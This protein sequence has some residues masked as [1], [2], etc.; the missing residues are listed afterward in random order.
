VR[1][2]P[3]SR[4]KD[5]GI[6]WLGNLPAHWTTSRLK[7]LAERKDLKVEPEGENPLP[8][9][10]LEHVES[11]TGKLLPLDADLVPEGISNRFSR[12]HT[13]F[14][15]LR[16]Y[17]AKGCNPDIDG[18]C[19]SELLVLQVRYQDRRYFLYQLLTEGFISFVDSSTYGAKMPRASWE[20]IGGCILPSPPAAEQH[21]IADFL[22]RKT[23]EVDALVAKKQALIEKLKEKRSALI[24][25]TVT[26]GLPP[27]VARAIGLDLQPNLKASGIDW[28]GDVPE[29]WGILM[30]K[31]TWSIC[32]YG[33]SEPLSG[34]GPVRVLTMRN[35]VAGHAIIPDEGCL[36]EIA[37]QMVLEDGDLLFN[38]TNS[39]VHVGKVGIYRHRTDELVTFASYLVRIRTNHRALPTFMNYLLNTQQL[40]EFVRGLALPSI[41]QANLNPTRYGQIQIPMPPMTEQRAI[42]DFLDRETTKI[43]LMVTKVEEAIE[44]LQ[45]YR[46]ALITAAVTGKIDV[47]QE[48]RGR[49]GQSGRDGQ[50]G[51]GQSR[52]RDKVDS[53]PARAGFHA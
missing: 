1:Y 2:R 44:R 4:Y 43:D 45:E 23:A 16:P 50:G 39:L 10:G 49:G 29:H 20:F 52:R 32:E 14:G 38:R 24:S 21:A 27:K 28:L 35:I 53:N 42:A 25:R 51:S 40:L 46:T 19:S 12:G 6:D 22:D 33:I 13:L 30:L 47:R 8:Y 3:Y 17:L 48:Q 34:T 9:V 11:W 31:R 37:P 36:E 7:F 5:S 15:K 26:R 41:N 18:L